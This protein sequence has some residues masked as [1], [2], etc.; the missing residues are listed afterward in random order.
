MDAGITDHLDLSE[1]DIVNLVT[2]AGITDDGNPHTLYWTVV[3]TGGSATSYQIRSVIVQYPATSDFSDVA[4]WGVSFSSFAGGY[5]LDEHGL[6]ESGG[7]WTWEPGNVLRALDHWA[8]NAVGWHTAIGVT[9]PQWLT[10]DMK[11]FK[12]LTGFYY[13]NASFG[14]AFPKAFT[15]DVSNDGTTWTKVLEYADFPNNT[16]LQTLDFENQGTFGGSS[17][18]ARYYRIN[19]TEVHG[20]HDHTFVARLK[21]IEP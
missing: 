15:I 16:T 4:D 10:V 11:S 3:P 20:G 9:M 21:P 1:S 2:L 8:A 7:S 19:I 14:S 13:W 12:K 17:I 5:D 6:A 18:W